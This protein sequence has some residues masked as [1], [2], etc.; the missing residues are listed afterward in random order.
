M[1]EYQ[2]ILT[3]EES[4]LYETKCDKKCLHMFKPKENYLGCKGV[5]K[6]DI[7]ITL[8]CYDKGKTCSELVTFR[9]VLEKDNPFKNCFNQEEI[10]LLEDTIVYPRPTCLTP[11]KMWL[12]PY[13]CTDSDEERNF[14]WKRPKYG[15]S[16]LDE[17][18]Y[19][20]THS[21]AAQSAKCDCK[22]GRWSNWD[23][24]C[25]AITGQHRK[26]HQLCKDKKCVLIRREYLV[27]NFTTEECTS[28]LAGLETCKFSVS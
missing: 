25:N 10:N 5:P 24:Q 12:S 22:W 14:D 28:K 11:D 3:D 18:G 1:A 20:I 15:T 23:E 2:D 13:S 19:I 4:E 21:Q 26:R 17:Q 27:K 9:K 16:C 7:S 6:R 8:E